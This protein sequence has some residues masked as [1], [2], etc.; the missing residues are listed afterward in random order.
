[1]ASDHPDVS[2]EDKS[3]D[4]ESHET[5][6]RSKLPQGSER[7]LIEYYFD[8]GLTYR[9]I[10]LMLEKHHNVVMTERTLKCWLSDYGC[11]RRSEIDNNFRRRVK[12]LILLEIRNGPDSLN[13][14]RTMWHILRLRHDINV[15]R[16]LVQ[17][18]LKVCK[19]E[20]VGA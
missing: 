18:I 12:D 10:T 17:R 19:G 20:S 2:T 5:S 8:R 6:I 16:S 14:Y 4:N 3:S 15:A 11:A 7:D 1:M 9:H 13:G